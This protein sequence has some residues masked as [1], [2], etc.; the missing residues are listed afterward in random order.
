MPL[1]ALILL[2][3]R[4][5][6]DDP[7]GKEGLAALTADMLDEGSG[8]R[9]A[10]EMH[11]ALARLGAQLDTDI[12][13]DAALVSVSVLTRYVER[14]LGLL[15]DVVV[16]PALREADFARVRQLRL[17]RLTQLRDAPSAIADRAFVKLLYGDHPYGHT[18][19]GTEQ[20]LAGLDVDDVRTFHAR[21]IR[22]AC[23]TLIAVG[24]C[25][26]D[27]VRQLAAAAFAGWEGGPRVVRAVGLAAAAPRGIVVVPRPGRRSRSCASATSPPRGPRP[28]TTRSSR[29]TWSSAGSSSAASI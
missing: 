27:T 5:S 25:D 13:A 22:P 8:D 18:P 28:I 19:I 2:I 10:I 7:P 3:R 20:A 4:G 11:E 23:S 16:R 9:S 14:T 6:A 29:P 21:G 15:A 26:H 17:H 1:V 24:D 12:G